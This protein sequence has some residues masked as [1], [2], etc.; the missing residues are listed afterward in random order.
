MWIKSISYIFI[1]AMKYDKQKQFMEDSLFGL[2]V[3]E[4][5]KSIM[6]WGEKMASIAAGAES[7]GVMP[8]TKSIKQKE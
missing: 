2:R 8:W 6:V 5:E 3:P 1:V 4:G 7:W